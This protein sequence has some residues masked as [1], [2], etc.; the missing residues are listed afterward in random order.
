MFGVVHW[1]FGTVTLH[2]IILKLGKEKKI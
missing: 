1:K 2:I